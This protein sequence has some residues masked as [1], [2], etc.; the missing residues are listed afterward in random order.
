MPPS[1]RS[2]Y[3]W[4]IYSR[5]VRAYVPDLYPGQV[6]LFRTH[7]RYRNGQ[8]PWAN[9]IAGALE[10]QELD[11]DHDDVFTEPYVQSFAEKLKTLLSEAQRNV[12]K[13]QDST[14]ESSV[15]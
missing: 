6:I 10:I 4:S 8:F 11:T 5:A 3:I 12:T 7:G 9:L 1:L 2:E 14:V 15:Q 13:R